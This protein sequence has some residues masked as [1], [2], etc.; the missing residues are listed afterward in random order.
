MKNLGIIQPGRLGDII[1]CLPIA[2]F[3][4]EQGYKVYW[5]IFENYIPIF[6]EAIDYVHFLPVASDIYSCVWQA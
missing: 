1:I 6:S 2:K 4:N 5:P 3:Y